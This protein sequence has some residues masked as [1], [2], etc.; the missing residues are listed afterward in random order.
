MKISVSYLSS[1]YDEEKTI[2]LIEQTNAD[3]IHVDLMDGGFVSTK[4]FTIEKVHHLLINHKKPLDIHLMVFDPIIYVHDLSILKPEVITFHIES[5]KDVVKTI[6]E[7]KKHG[8]KVGLSIKIDTDI[9]ELMPYL[10]LIDVVLIMSVNPGRGGQTF[11]MSSINRLNELQKIREENH[12]SFLI[13]MDGGINDEIIKLVSS[14]DIAVSGSYI[15]KYDDYQ[16]RIDKLKEE[17]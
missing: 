4:N 13:E 11:M 8:I 14:L 12:L 10:S 2:K 7:I 5:T 16:A 1:K 6:E 15:C 9:Y 17:V 3:Y